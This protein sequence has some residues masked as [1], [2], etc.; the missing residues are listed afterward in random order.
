MGLQIKNDKDLERRD[1]K[2]YSVQEGAAEMSKKTINFH[3]TSNQAVEINTMRCQY[4]DGKF[5][6][7][8]G[9][10]LDTCPICK[11]EFH[12]EPERELYDSVTYQLIVD[13]RT[14]VPNV[15]KNEDYEPI[16]QGAL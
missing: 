10:E 12:D 16:V 9:Q 6:E 15:I 7:L 14:G 2:I 3:E 11:T 4:C 13:A 5:Y 8:D 1:T